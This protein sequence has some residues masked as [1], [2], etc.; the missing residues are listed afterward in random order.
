TV[1]DD[2]HRDGLEAKREVACVH[3]EQLFH[4]LRFERSRS[5]PSASGLAYADDASEAEMA[6]RRVDGLRHSRRGAVAAAV[7]RRAQ[8]GATLHHLARYLDVG[9]LRVET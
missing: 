2:Q 8:E 1:G 5:G 6:R 4:S 3:F 9:R 7:V